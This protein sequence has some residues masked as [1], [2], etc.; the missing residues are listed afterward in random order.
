[1]LIHHIQGVPRV[2]VLLREGAAYVKL[3][4]Y[5]PKHT[6]ITQNTYIQSCTVWEIMGREV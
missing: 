6:D 3:Y 2:K 4:R 5:N 1:M